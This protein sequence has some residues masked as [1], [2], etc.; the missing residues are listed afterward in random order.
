V[1]FD[2]PPG[3]VPERVVAVAARILPEES[4]YESERAAVARAVPK[5]RYEYAAGRACARRA[6]EELGCPPAPLLSRPDRM[7][8]W[9]VGFVGSI[10]HSQ[11]GAFAVVARA[12]ELVSL[13]ADLEGDAPLDPQLWSL[14][15]TP[16]E[17]PGAT[18]LSMKR[19]FCAKEAAFKCWF[20]AGGGRILEFQEMVIRW[21]AGGAFVALG[22]PLPGR[23]A[24]IGRLSQQGGHLWCVSWMEL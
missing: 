19:L 6:L 18:G 24:P 4:P 12:H 22:P 8:Q 9:P 3:L 1:S 5:R 17:L 16:A 23:K 11:T 15:A 10:S 14:V 7:P 21:E 13:G 2:L 20:A